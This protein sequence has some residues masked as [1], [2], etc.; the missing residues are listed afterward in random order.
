M[1]F[2]CLT[3][4]DFDSKA[5]GRDFYRVTAYD[6]PV[7]AGELERLRAMDKVMAD[8]RIAASDREADRFFQLAGFRKV[9]VQVRF[10]ATVD[11]ALAGGPD[12]DDTAERSLPAAA[13]ARHVDNLTYDR[14]NLDAFVEKAGR[15]RFQTAWI[16]NSLAS[17]SIRKV[18]DGESF[19]SF[20]ISGVEAVVDVVS[21]LVHRSGVGSALLRRVFAA[22]ARAGCV[23]LVVTTEI[24][25][26]PACRL[27]AKSGFSPEAWFSRFHYVSPVGTPQTRHA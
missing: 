26:E 1:G 21:V 8:A 19:V 23:R 14:F 3:R 6:Y 22:A 15:D 13:V 16:A 24:E 9:T 5:F 10:A 2:T 18:Y 25:N 11:P 27:Y 12:P 4:Q 20:K 7:L 17:P